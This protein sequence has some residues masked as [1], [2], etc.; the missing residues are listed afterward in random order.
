MF[1]IFKKKKSFKVE[2]KDDMLEFYENSK[3]IFRNN[4]DSNTFKKIM[5]LAK[6][7]LAEELDGKVKIV[8]KDGSIK[9]INLR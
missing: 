1:N 5:A 9:T 2:L 4:S 6:I 7:I 8:N 3:F